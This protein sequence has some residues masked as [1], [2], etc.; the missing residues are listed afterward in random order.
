MHTHAGDQECEKTI[1]MYHTTYIYAKCVSLKAMA[2]ICMPISDYCWHTC[3]NGVAVLLL[4]VCLSL[5][6]SVTMCVCYHPQQVDTG[7]F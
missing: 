4:S 6:H 2:P 3:I 5:Y 1:S 7:T